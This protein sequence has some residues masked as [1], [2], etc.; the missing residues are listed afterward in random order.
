MN[1]DSAVGL[2][3]G[4]WGGERELGQLYGPLNT[5]E[6]AI[7]CGSGRQGGG[8]RGYCSQLRSPGEMAS[9]QHECAAVSWGAWGG[10][11]GRHL[12]LCPALLDP[13]TKASLIPIRPLL[14]GGRGG[15]LG[16]LPGPQA[17]SSLW[18]W[19]MMELGGSLEIFSP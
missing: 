9:F 1:R 2:P 3:F 7:K 18:E 5:H 8:K 12:A 15:G 4:G 11:G 13:T 16:P 17:K 19:E 10:A 6:L 14:G